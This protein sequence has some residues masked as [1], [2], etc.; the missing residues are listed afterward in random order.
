MKLI[1]LQPDRTVFNGEVYS[2]A[3]PGKGGKFELLTRHAPLISTL[4]PGD[5]KYRKG[6]SDAIEFLSI[7]GGFIKIKQNVITICID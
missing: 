3:L 1:I 2:V 5:I 6:K 7:K 4:K